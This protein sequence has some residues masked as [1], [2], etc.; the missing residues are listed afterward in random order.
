MERKKLI[1]A[2]MALM[3]VAMMAQNHRDLLSD[4]AMHVVDRYVKMLDI[5]HLP[6]D[7]MLVMETAVTTNLN[8][9]DTIW[10]RRWFA[11]GERHRIEVW[12]DQKMDY[13][14]SSNGK[15]R[16]RTYRTAYESWESINSEEFN[17]KLQGYDFR[18]PLYRWNEKGAQLSWNGTTELK[19]Q[20]LQVVKVVC[21][22]MY[23]R[24]YMFEPESGLLTLIFETDEWEG[25]KKEIRRGHIE[26]KIFHEF[27]PLTT[28]MLPSLESFMRDGELTI[29]RTSY[30][31]EAVDP[32]IFEHD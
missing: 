10:M 8:T 5:D 20:P 15:D 29:L 13:G 32:D 24:Y 3:P 4:S 25:S 12:N 17:K 21:P 23:T 27:Q 31:F 19:G 30:H 28:G 18:G 7:S 16:F 9:K 26:W 11:A 14:L 1:V 2:L 22:N 6:T